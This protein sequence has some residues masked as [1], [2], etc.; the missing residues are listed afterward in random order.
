MEFTSPPLD[1]PLALVWGLLGCDWSVYLSHLSMTCLSRPWVHPSC[2][3]V[4]V[5]LKP[6]KKTF[7]Y[8]SASSL[9]SR[10]S[11]LA[12]PTFSLRLSLSVPLPSIKGSLYCLYKGTGVVNRCRV[13]G[14]RLAARH[15][16]GRSPP[17]LYTLSHTSDTLLMDCTHHSSK[18]CHWQWAISSIW[19]KRS[20]GFVSVDTSSAFTSPPDYC[21]GLWRWRSSAKLGAHFFFLCVQVCVGLFSRPLYSFSRSCDDEANEDFV[22]GFNKCEVLLREPWQA[23]NFPLIRWNSRCKLSHLY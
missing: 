8:S 22:L 10:L 2:P 4:L 13:M 6:N 16:E 5:S 19:P 12:F 23:V 7:L 3:G 20:T 14:S 21:Q 11:P 1:G 15:Q 9:S 18:L 17:L